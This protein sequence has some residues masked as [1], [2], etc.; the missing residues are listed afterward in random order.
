MAAANKRHRIYRLH[1]FIDTRQINLAGRPNGYSAETECRYRHSLIGLMKTESAVGGANKIFRHIVGI[2]A[3]RARSAPGTVQVAIASAAGFIDGQPIFIPGELVDRLRPGQTAIRGFEHRTG[4]GSL[5]GHGLI[6]KMPRGIHIQHRVGAF[7][8]RRNRQH[9]RT[10]TGTAIETIRV[11]G[12]FESGIRL[13]TAPANNDVTGI[14]RIY[15]NGRFVALIGRGVVSV[16]V[17]IDLMA[18]IG[19]KRDSG[20]RCRPRRCGRC[21][22]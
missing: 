22:A 18:D 8:S 20:R 12:L 21:D 10:P 6:I 13:E 5:V 4:I 11:S 15:R 2:G 19:A 16:D 1:G 3:G 14:E 17:D 7:G 9:V